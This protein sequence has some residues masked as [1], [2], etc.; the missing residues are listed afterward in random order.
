MKSNPG[1]DPSGETLA[2]ISSNAGVA[3]ARRPVRIDADLPDCATPESSST[4]FQDA[5]RPFEE[6]WRAGTP[7]QID[8]FVCEADV[9][10]RAWALTTL[11]MKIDLEWRLRRGDAGARIEDYVARYPR[12]ADPTEDLNVWELIR[13]EVG[14]RRQNEELRLAEYERRFPR[15][16]ELLQRLFSGFGGTPTPVVPGYDILDRLGKGGLGVVYRARHRALD[17]FVALKVLAKAMDGDDDAVDITAEARAVARLNHP[18]VVR[19]F[20]C[21]V[22]ESGPYFTMELMEGGSLQDR[23]GDGPLPAREAAEIVQAIA[24]G[25][26]AAHQR[27][28][29][30]RDLKPANVLLAVGGV[31]KVADFGM[32]K[33]LRGEASVT[34]T[35]T[36]RGT[37][38]YMAPEQV[39]KGV[40]EVG[41]LTDVYGLGAVLYASLTG[42]PPFQGADYLETFAL[43]EVQDPVAIRALRRDVPRDLQTVC[44]KC[45]RKDP[46]HRYH[47]AEELA[48]DLKRFLEGRPVAARPVGPVVKAVSWAR[49][50]PTAAGLWFAVLLAALAL[51]LAAVQHHRAS[52]EMRGRLGTEVRLAIQRGSP[53]DMQ[54]KI[55]EAVRSGLTPLP[56]QQFA[57]AEALAL[58]NQFPE[59]RAALDNLE[60]ESLPTS[61]RSQVDLLAADLMLAMNADS[62]RALERVRRSL[63]GQL[64]AADKCYAEGLLAQSP[65]DAL[66][67]FERAVNL[68]HRHFRARVVGSLLLFSMGRLAEAATWCEDSLLL[69]DNHPNPLIV[70]YLA[71]SLQGDTDRTA[72]AREA[73]KAKVPDRSYQVLTAFVDVIPDLRRAYLARVHGEPVGRTFNLPGTS[74]LELF[75]SSLGEVP[76]FRPPHGLLFGYRQLKQE[77]AN[78]RAGQRVALFGIVSPERIQPARDELAKSPEGFM[79]VL[80][81]QGIMDLASSRL[82]PVKPEH[83][84]PEGL[85]ETRRLLAEA[86]DEFLNAASMPALIDLRTTAYENAAVSF[87]AA[88]ELRGVPKVYPEWVRKSGRA[89]AER[90]RLDPPIHRSRRPIII[91][92]ALKAED[93]ESARRLLD[94]W[95]RE[96]PNSLQA[97]ETRASVEEKPNPC[98]ALAAA[99]RVLAKQPTNKVMLEVRDRCRAQL[100]SLVAS[101]PPAD[102]QQ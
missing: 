52:E 72:A 2:Q 6:A 88:G 64:S 97:L 22:G 26:H 99:E 29:I 14:A 95:D 82:P 39:R 60:S 34:Q 3:K 75:D 27:G 33:H 73:L 102:K 43:V 4:D 46:L 74:L 86:G 98:A 90:L 100:R 83:G 32:A 35:H 16:R 45:L 65:K 19:V 8:D 54:E 5:A 13:V 38:S 58:L 21:G 37:P 31:A 87:S 94:D 20:D 24:T 85:D 77:F 36:A 67:Y 12:L 41:P 49:R 70:R 62:E 84:T 9:G 57:Y 11:L 1:Q 93:Y 68:D 55:A 101:F 61:V 71:R 40:K 59:A 10:P 23:L 78:V 28:I 18:H 89:V 92:A 51:G 53:K 69:A 63:Q 81:A 50:R 79:H 47:S 76:L 91:K 17:Q 42:R 44:E 96:E 15:H 80:F 48:R 7:L 25:V 66:P 56:E 30:H